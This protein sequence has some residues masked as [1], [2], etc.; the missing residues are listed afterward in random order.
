MEIEKKRETSWKIQLKKKDESIEMTSVEISGEV[1]FIKLA[2]VNKEKIE[3]T[4]ILCK[5]TGIKKGK[6]L[7][8]LLKILE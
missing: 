1:R 4:K 8:T 5:A 7:L 6:P 2:L 3:G